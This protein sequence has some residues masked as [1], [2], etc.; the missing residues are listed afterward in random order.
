VLVEPRSAESLAR[1]IAALLDAP[2]RCRAMGKAGRERVLQHF[3]WRKAAERHV[4][5]YREVIEQRS[6]TRVAC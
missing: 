1:E 6:D 5:V 4:E 2:E 3:T